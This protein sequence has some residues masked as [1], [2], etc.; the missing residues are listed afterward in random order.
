PVL[1][2]R[3]KVAPEVAISGQS[4]EGILEGLIRNVPSPRQ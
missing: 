4:V 3:V 2:H 1:R